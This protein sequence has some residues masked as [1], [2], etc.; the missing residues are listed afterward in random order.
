MTCCLSRSILALALCALTT[1]CITSAEQIA[2]RNNQRC[3]ARG[4]QPDTK[5]F[6][7]CLARVETER[8]L[9]MQSRHQE[10]I[11]RSAVPP[12]NRGN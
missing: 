10:I 2:E 4:Y 9:R 6:N 12:S 5:D 3:V 8:S 7:D 1:G 11:E